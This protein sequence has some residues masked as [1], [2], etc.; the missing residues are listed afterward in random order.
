MQKSFDTKSRLLSA[1]ANK[2]VVTNVAKDLA[3]P[4]IKM[5]YKNV[6]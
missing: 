2:K 1:E 6:Q 3:D 4:V 5:L